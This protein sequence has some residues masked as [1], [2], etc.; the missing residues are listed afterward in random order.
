M[1]KD[2]YLKKTFAGGSR[3][4][5]VAFGMCQA[6]VGLEALLGFVSQLCV[7][8]VGVN[9]AEGNYDLCL[10][11]DFN[12]MKELEAYK[13]HPEHVKI[14]SYC[15]LVCASKI[16]PYHIFII[17]YCKNRPKKGSTDKK[18]EADVF[19]FTFFILQGLIIF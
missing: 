3:R 10:I 6:I 1:N 13:I 2:K 5:S 16:P 11:A 19:R 17:T 18:S 7:C 12:S 15:R 8:R 14:A 4:S 9:I